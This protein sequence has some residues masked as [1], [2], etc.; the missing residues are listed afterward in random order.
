M[1]ETIIPRFFV[2]LITKDRGIIY[3]GGSYEEK[4]FLAYFDTDFDVRWF[5]R[6]LYKAA[7]RVSVH[8]DGSCAF[9][10]A[11]AV[12]NAYVVG[13]SAEPAYAAERIDSFRQARVDAKSV[14]LRPDSQYILA[15]RYE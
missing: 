4:V 8:S 7:G 13:R 5:I 2:R 12:F 6:Y 9:I 10:A 15:D 14:E 11:C 1:S 3:I